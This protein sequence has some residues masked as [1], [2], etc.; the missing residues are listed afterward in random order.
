VDDVVDAL[1]RAGRKRTT[2]GAIYHVVGDAGITR[3]TLARA[4]AAGDGAR[5]VI[6]PRRALLGLAGGVE[7]LGRALGRT[8]PLS[9]YRV[10][11]TLARVRFDCTRAARDLGWRPSGAALIPRVSAAGPDSAFGAPG[12]GPAADTPTGSCVPDDARERRQH[13]DGAEMARV[14][15][16]TRA[17]PARTDAPDVTVRGVVDAEIVTDDGAARREDAID[18]VGEPSGHLFV[19]D[20]GQ[21]GEEQDVLEGGIGEGEGFA[22]PC[23]NEGCER[24]AHDEIGQEIDPAQ[25]LGARTSGTGSRAR[26]RCR[27]R[28]PARA[29][30][31]AGQGR[32][33]RGRAGR[34]SRSATMARLPGLAGDQRPSAAP[35]R[36]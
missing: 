28:P 2:A 4:I 34:L 30:V 16:T 20:R 29:R 19:E 6:P 23:S 27:S 17:M 18:L 3:A 14:P 31:R 21:H 11:S 12:A 8:P 33:R 15:E 10:R 22:L 24:A 25:A 7:L 32:W 1:L 26:R 35:S 36:A 9:R 13:G 5:V